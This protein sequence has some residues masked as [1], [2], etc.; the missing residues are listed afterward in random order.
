[1]VMASSRKFH[2]NSTE[3][4]TEQENCIGNEKKRGEREKKMKELKK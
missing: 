4:E 1:M 2:S 3:E